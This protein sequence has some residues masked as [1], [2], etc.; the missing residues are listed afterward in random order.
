M[1]AH[2]PCRACSSTLQILRVRRLTDKQ[3]AKLIA[4]VDI[5]KDGSVGATAPHALCPRP[6]QLCSGGRP[7]L[8]QCCLYSLSLSSASHASPGPV[9][10]H[11]Q[12]DFAEFCTMMFEGSSHELNEAFRPK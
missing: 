9:P 2:V 1:H 4:E 8:R 6:G 3:V 5:N 12:V 10:A 11:P 7:C